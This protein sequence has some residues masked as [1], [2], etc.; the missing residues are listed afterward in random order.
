[1]GKISQRKHYQTKEDYVH[2]ILRESILNCDYEPGEKLVIDRLSEELE[3]STIPI[4]ASIQRL[5]MEGLVIVKPHSPAQV[6]PITI[7]MIQ[8]TFALLA[9]LEMIAFEQIAQQA[10]PQTIAKLEELVHAM[11]K[12]LAN[13]N[14]QAWADINIEF[15][16][17]I[18]KASQMPLLLE[19]TN[20]TLDQWRRVS[21]YYFKEVA[22]SR[23]LIAQQEHREVISMIKSGDVEG[24]K[25]LAQRHN[26]EASKAYQQMVEEQTQLPGVVR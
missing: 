5:G 18:A 24:L 7:N 1:M 6:S 16:R 14:N 3:I 8:E 11:E 10:E 22:S 12:S 2:D 4:R 9:S 13:N 17:Q 19:F 23:M 21:Q 26:L 20:R 15:H 25:S